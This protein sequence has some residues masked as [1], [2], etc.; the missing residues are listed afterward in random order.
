MSEADMYRQVNKEIIAYGSIQDDSAFSESSFNPLL[1]WGK[2]KY[3]L[4]F[5]ASA[6]KQILVIQA[7][8]AESERHF[9][10]AGRVTRKDR[11]RL[12]TKTVEAQVLLAEA[13]MK[14]IIV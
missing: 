8:S 13:L 2:Q 6:A 12:D 3:R 9:S 11:A 10:T 7:S 5:L 4:P 14:K 1:W